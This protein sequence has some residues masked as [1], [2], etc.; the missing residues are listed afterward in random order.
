M[1]VARSLHGTAAA[2]TEA[3]ELM[4][5]AGE[6]GVML[7]P[8]HPGA[9]DLYLIP[10]FTVEVA[11]AAHAAQVIARLQTSEAVEAA[12]LKPADELP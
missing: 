7:T 10:F 6:L 2:T 11:D 1:D 3:H 4:Q 8:M 12:Y 5:L 9:E